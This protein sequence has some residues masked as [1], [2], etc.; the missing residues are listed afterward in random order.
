MMLVGGLGLQG[1][2][3]SNEALRTVYEDRT[4]CAGQLSDILNTMQ[5]NVRLLML[6]AAGDPGP[7]TRAAEIRA[8]SAISIRSGAHIWPPT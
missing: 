5:R 7:A 1:I 2:G 8:I 3:R 4:I 6:I